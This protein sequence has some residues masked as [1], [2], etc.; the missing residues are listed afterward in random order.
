MREG[1]HRQPRVV[2]Q[3]DDQSVDVA[4]LDRFGEPA[5]DVARERLFGETRDKKSMR[6]LDSRTVGDRL[7]YLTY[8]LVRET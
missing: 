4:V 5:D 2:G 6:L 3:E 8:G 1:R 7:A